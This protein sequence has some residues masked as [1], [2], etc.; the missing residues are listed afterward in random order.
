[1]SRRWVR[2]LVSAVLLAAFV[3]LGWPYFGKLDL[4]LR[5]HPLWLAGILLVYC[6]TRVLNAQVMCSALNRLGRRV[7]IYEAFMLTMVTSYTN[8]LVPHAGLGAPALYMKRKYSLP[9]SDFAAALMSMLVLQIFCAGVIGLVGAAALGLREGWVKQA[10]LLALFGTAVC[11]ST[12]GIFLRIPLRQRWK[13]SLANAIRRFNRSWWLLRAS[14]RLVRN[15]LL[16]HAVVTVLRGVRLQLAFH[17]VGA[18][19]GF[20][21]TLLASICSQFMLLIHLTPG[22]MGFREAAIVAVYG[23]LVGDAEIAMAAAL[24]DR[25]VWTA[26]IILISQVGLWQLV[27]PTLGGAAGDAAG[28][29]K[30][31][32]RG[33]TDRQ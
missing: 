7:G 30:E 31:D 24:L 5:P 4:L 27:R 12:A 23:H 17:A 25:I 8:L 6:F 19:G 32:K 29:D 26:A 2:I 15:I 14:P 1:M 20:L 28:D 10:P 16:I 33:G 13:G 11:G 3:Y 18:G 22:A 9:Y 21:K